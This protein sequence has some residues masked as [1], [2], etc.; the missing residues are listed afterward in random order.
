[1]WGSGMVRKEGKYWR[2]QIQRGGVMHSSTFS[3]KA[4]AQEFES[5]IIED[6]KHKRS[7]TPT[8]YTIAQAFTRWINEE[9]P[10]LRSRRS[11]ANHAKQLLPYIDGLPLSDMNTAWVA[12]KKYAAKTG[13]AIGTINR[14]GAVLRRIANLAYRKWQWLQSPVFIELLPEP[15]RKRNT[16]ITKPELFKLLS[17]IQCKYTEALVM[18]LFYSGMRVGEALNVKVSNGYF[19]IERSKSGKPRTIKIHDSL[20]DAVKLLPLPFKYGYYYKRF[21]SAAK[22][23]GMGNLH[24]HDIRHSFASHLLNHGVGLKTVSD[25][26]GHHSISIT[27]DIYGHIYRPDLDSAITSI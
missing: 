27:S 23:A 5:R 14:K 16:Y 11:T 9:L 22:S 20:E 8:E 24:I 26:L 12:Y 7:G 25:L 21:T 19:V 18:I 17:F 2:V 10:D 1:M 4:Q 13:L 3:T 6:H 15:R